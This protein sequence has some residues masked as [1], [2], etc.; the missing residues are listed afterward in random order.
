MEQE[1]VFCPKCKSTELT[2]NKKGFSAGQAVGGALL[3]GG[4]GL[5]AGAIGSGK[6]RITCLNCG[7]RFKPGDHL[8][9]LEKEST[10]KKQP[11]EG[12]SDTVGTIVVV[13]IIIFLLYLIF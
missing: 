11:Q 8:K 6:V 3:T 2:A 1:K 13:G 5:V 10:Y 4:I 9:A 7:N 12:G